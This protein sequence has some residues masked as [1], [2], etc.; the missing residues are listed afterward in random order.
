VTWPPETLDD[1]LALSV[2]AW[3]LIGVPTMLLAVLVGTLVASQRRAGK[4][5]PAPARSDRRR[6]VRLIGLCHVGLALWCLT[7]VTGELWAYRTMGIFPSNP[8]TGL[9]GS[10]VAMAVD[11]P[12]GVGLC[13]LWRWARWGAVVLAAIRVAFAVIAIRYVWVHGAVVDWAEWPRFVVARAMPFFF[14]V[15]LLLPGTAQA[16]DTPKSTVLEP[17]RGDLLTL[18]MT[19]LFAVLLGSVVATDVLDWAIRTVVEELGS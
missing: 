2:S 10:L 17:Q 7:T 6:V 12:V 3:N 15:V 8:V 5:D 14:L 4:P 16:V 13:F 1:A 18:V 19:R 9:P 11:V